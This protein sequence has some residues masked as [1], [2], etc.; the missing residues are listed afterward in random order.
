MSGE[1]SSASAE[2]PLQRDRRATEGGRRSNDTSGYRRLIELG[3][4]LSAERNRNALIERILRGAKDLCN[5]DGGTLYLVTDDE[6]HLGFAIMLNN[7]LDV[8]LGGTT[9][10]P[11]PFPPIPLFG[12]DGA[13]NYK[14]VATFCALDGS[15]I[16]IADA[17]DNANFDFAGTKAF[18]A[19]TGYRSTSFL[20]VPLKNHDQEVIGVLQLINRRTSDDT[21]VIPFTKDLV[22]MVE[23]LASQAAVALDNQNLIQGQKDLMEAFIKVI[24][25]G[26]DAKSPHTGG[27][28]QRV[29]VLTEQLAQASCETTAG[30][31]AAFDMTEEEWYELHIAAWMHDCGKIT[32]PEHVVEKST[33]LQTITDRV[34]EVAARFEVLKRDA[35]IAA[36]K[37][38]LADAG[39]DP[40]VDADADLAAL[41]DDLAFIETANIGGEFMAD[42]KVA[43]VAEIARR[44]WMHKGEERPLLTE[45]EVYNLSIKKGTLND[46]ER[47]IIND[48][49]VLTI[50]MLEQLPFPKNLRRVPEY[51]GGHH[52]KMDGTGYP[53]GLTRE[54]MSWPARMMAI[55]DIFEALTAADRPYKK[56][57]PL[58]VAMSILKNM[59]DDR[60]IDPDLFEVF[61]RQKVYLR[62]AEEF[63]SPDQIDEFDT[64]GW[65]DDRAA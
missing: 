64:T 54:Q 15:T 8:A 42:E 27:H 40:N 36:L 17:Y 24:A 49:I 5:A 48:H 26:I 35:E 53:R 63:L 29:P 57:M 19:K 65:F 10:K 62:Y 43:R 58:S 23:A 32:T 21:T 2:A 55:A 59:R 51:A 28:C 41:T 39:L 45:N 18:D 37:R 3:I 20:T 16:N 47:Q 6:K 31:L 33:K 11:I 56:P 60:H 34:S 25:M 44:T 22:P 46:E 7:S 30:P 50:D 9:G 14:N 52:E 4:A 13:P 1:P 12:E 38:K 61:V